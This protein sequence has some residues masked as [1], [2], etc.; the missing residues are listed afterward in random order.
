[1]LGWCVQE[2]SQA[3]HVL[4]PTLV[5]SETFGRRINAVNS[6]FWHYQ[7]DFSLDILKAANL[8]TTNQTD[9][10]L[11]KAFR[12]RVE[13]KEKK[14]LSTSEY[15]QK[16][17]SWIQKCMNSVQLPS[18]LPKAFYRTE[19]LSIWGRLRGAMEKSSIWAVLPTSYS[20]S[21]IQA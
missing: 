15:K 13:N 4:P 17:Y 1:M 3:D 6:T 21:W 16:N 9:Q 5:I 14:S 18:N 12:M 7:P 11:P 8:Y 19:F 2:S 20:F 10:C